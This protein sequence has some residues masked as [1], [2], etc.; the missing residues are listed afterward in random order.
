MMLLYWWRF[1]IISTIEELNSFVC[2]LGEI[3]KFEEFKNGEK[4]PSKDVNK[5]TIKY[6]SNHKTKN[7]KQNGSSRATRWC[8]Y[9]LCYAWELSNRSFIFLLLHI[10]EY[11]R[12]FKQFCMIIEG[13]QQIWGIQ[14]GWKVTFQI[15]QEKTIKYS[16]NHK[17]KKI[18][19]NGSSITTRWY[20]Y[21]FYAMPESQAI[22]VI[23]FTVI[24]GHPVYMHKQSILHKC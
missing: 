18:N 8:Q 6:S 16:S 3:S 2:E 24:V 22:R 10:I 21:S 19:Q 14:K 5:K 20:Q 13:N 11:K 9:I 17:T 12:I 7:I 15:C 4:W 23:Y 1:Q